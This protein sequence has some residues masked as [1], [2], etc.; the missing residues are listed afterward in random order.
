MKKLL[1][2]A[3]IFAAVMICA[4]A[5]ALNNNTFQPAGATGNWNV[6][7]NWS[8]GVPGAGDNAIIPDGKTC[9]VNVSDARAGAFTVQGAGVLSVNSSCMLE[10]D[11]NSSVNATGG[12]LLTGSGSTLRISGNLTISGNGSLEGQDNS[13][14]VELSSSCTLTLASTTTI[15]GA[16]QLVPKS[17][18]SNT[19]FLNLGTVRADRSSNTL[20]VD[21][22]ALD[23]AC[24]TDVDGDWEVADYSTSKLSLR[25]SSTILQGDFSVTNGTLDVQADIMTSGD[26]SFTGGKIEVAAGMVFRTR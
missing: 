15:E 16:L 20:V 4:P 23:D 9:Y 3:A 1:T 25:I 17:G 19:T 13:A 10:I 24:T 8:G 21:V 6:A 7:G 5:M 11:N 18:A 14:Q 2:T 26:L 22:D 12:V